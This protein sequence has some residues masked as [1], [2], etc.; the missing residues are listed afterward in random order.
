MERF[1]RID[2]YSGGISLAVSG[3]EVD[4]CMV[5]LGLED[6]RPTELVTDTR[7]DSD[8]LLTP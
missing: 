1:S 5:E 6:A 8:L 4:S 2:E 3:P 7:G